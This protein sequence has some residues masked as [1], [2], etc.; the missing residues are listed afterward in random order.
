MVHRVH[1]VYTTEQRMDQ[2]RNGKKEDH[3][4]LPFDGVCPARRCVVC[5][6]VHSFAPRETVVVFAIEKGSLCGQI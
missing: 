1:L 5:A 4:K 3:G 2:N 6:V